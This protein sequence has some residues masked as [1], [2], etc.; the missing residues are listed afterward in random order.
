MQRFP[1]NGFAQIIRF[2]IRKRNA[3]HDGGSFYRLRRQHIQSVCGGH[4][5]KVRFF[6]KV[7]AQRVV[8]YVDYAAK[9]GKQRGIDGR[10]VRV[11][12]HSHGGGVDQKIRVCM[13]RYRFFVGDCI[14]RFFSRY[15]YDFFCAHIRKYRKK[16]LPCA[17]GAEY[18]RFFA[19]HLYVC[20][21]DQAFR[22]VIIGIIAV[23]LSVSVHD[24]IHRADFFRFGRNSA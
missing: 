17:A 10:F 6:R 20:A 13:Q 15:R 1:I 14:R 12:I 8:N 11:R 9:T 18:Q 24:E 2:R 4:A 19:F 22:A 3:A 16:S 7:G 21:F 23:K 5:E